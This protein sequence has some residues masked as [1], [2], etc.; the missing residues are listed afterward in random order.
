MTSW[1]NGRPSGASNA[2]VRAGPDRV[3]TDTVSRREG[4]SSPLTAGIQQVGSD[5]NRLTAEEED[6]RTSMSWGP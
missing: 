4:A 6:P 1:R 5:N 3:S 2:L